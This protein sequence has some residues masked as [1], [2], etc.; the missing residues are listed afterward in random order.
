MLA[1]P[2]TGQSAQRKA[3]VWAVIGILILA[4]GLGALLVGLK[5]LEKV[6]PKVGTKAR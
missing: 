6:A 4:L 3:I 1:T 2:P 5:Q